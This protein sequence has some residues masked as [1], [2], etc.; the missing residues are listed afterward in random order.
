MIFHT[1]NAIALITTKINRILLFSH[2]KLLNFRLK[3]G[4]SATRRKDNK[5][6]MVTNDPAITELLRLI[7]YLSRTKGM[8]LTKKAHAG[9][10]KPINCSDCRSSVLN[11]ASRSAEN[12]AILNAR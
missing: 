12:K 5:R 10:G 11:L 9:V 7:K 8:A 6:E 4:N 3:R 2:L 1:N